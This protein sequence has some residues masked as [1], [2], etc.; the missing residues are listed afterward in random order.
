[1]SYQP[2]EK[3][4]LDGYDVAAGWDISGYLGGGR[5]KDVSQMRTKMSQRG[6][7]EKSRSG[8]IRTIERANHLG[9]PTKLKL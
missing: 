2:L 1:M 3:A 4:F 5:L 7:E 8:T 9:L 6:I